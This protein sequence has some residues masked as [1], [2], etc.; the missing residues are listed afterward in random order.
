MQLFFLGKP[1]VYLDFLSFILNNIKVK[2]YHA[3]AATWASSS[4]CDDDESKICNIEL[5]EEVH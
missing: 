2:V 4:L 5:K 1:D 3:G